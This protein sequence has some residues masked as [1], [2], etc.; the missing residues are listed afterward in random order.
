MANKRYQE[1][2]QV[3]RNTASNDLRNLIEKKIIIKIGAEKRGL[4]YVLR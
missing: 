1:V 4:K 2:F 3:S